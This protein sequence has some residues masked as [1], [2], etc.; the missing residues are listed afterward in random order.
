MRLA[1]T[2]SLRFDGLPWLSL[3]SSSEHGGFLAVEISE[4][5]ASD[6]APG[7]DVVIFVP[8]GQQER[9]TRAIAAFN[10]A[11]GAEGD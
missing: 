7:G 2:L 6:N 1:G 4:R 11:M 3:F 5:G 8:P 10:L 9:L